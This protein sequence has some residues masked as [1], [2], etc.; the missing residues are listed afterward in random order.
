MFSDAAG[1]RAVLP[2]RGCL[3]R[4]CGAVLPYPRKQAGQ[5]E[6]KDKPY[7]AVIWNKQAR[8]TVLIITSE[9]VGFF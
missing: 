3:G 1:Y 9:R 8:I 2:I 6:K 7:M 4:G 5:A